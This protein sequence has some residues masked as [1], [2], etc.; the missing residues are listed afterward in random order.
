[1]KRFNAFYKSLDLEWLRDFFLQNGKP[2]RFQRGEIFAHAGESCRQIGLVTSGYFK[3]CVTGSSGNEA[4][5]G[6]SFTN[7]FAA[8]LVDYLCGLRSQTSIVAGSRSELLVVPLEQF[9][10]HFKK[11]PEIQ[12]HDI[13]I[14][15]L[16]TS[17]S[18]YLDTF[19]Y[20][21][22]ERYL[23]LMRHSGSI[24]NDIRLQEIAS[25]LRITPQY[26]SRLRREIINE[27]KNAL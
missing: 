25:Y 10:D 6:F 4:I 17:Y 8:P 1:M 12:L 19:R 18:R 14:P 23:N 7:E 5:T 15:L 2:R 21:P 22:K 11:N 3:F 26:L 9:T 16:T 24:L 27:G 13:L 20:S